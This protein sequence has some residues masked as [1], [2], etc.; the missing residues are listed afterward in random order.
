MTYL[1]L[2]Q[3]STPGRIPRISRL[4]ERAPTPAATGAG[5]FSTP[6]SWNSSSVVVV[7]AQEPEGDSW[8]S[9]SVVVVLDSE[10]FR[11]SWNSCCKNSKNLRGA[12]GK[13][14]YA[15]TSHSLAGRIPRTSR[16]WP[17]KNPHVKTVFSM[18][19]LRRVDVSKFPGLQYQAPRR[20]RTC[21][22]TSVSVV[23]RAHVPY[24]LS[25]RRGRLARRRRVWLWRVVV[26]W[27]LGEVLD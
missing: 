4:P 11:D 20:A 3:A 26:G 17:G 22:L 15:Q 7:S 1:I 23:A 19:E 9:S 16:I 14:P 21:N 2:L 12:R 6:D 18:S 5:F 10:F 24:R 27:A 8:N 25:S 13:N